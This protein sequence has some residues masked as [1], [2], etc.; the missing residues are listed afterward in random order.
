[1]ATR[2]IKDKII[3]KLNDFFEIDIYE[4]IEKRKKKSLGFSQNCNNFNLSYIGGRKDILK[5]VPKTAKKVLDVGCSTGAVGETIRQKIGDVEISGI[6][7]SERMAQ[8]ARG[9][10]DKVVIEDIEKLNPLEQFDSNYFDCIIFADILEHLKNPWVVLKNMI[11]I[12]DE[13]GLVILSIPNIRHYS[14]IIQLVFK[15]YW[16][17][18]ERGIHDK[19]H[20]RF[21][22]LKNIKELLE[23]AGLEP[24]NIRRKYRI[25]ERPHK[26]NLFAKFF[27]LPILRVFLTFQYVIC[28]KKKKTLHKDT[29]LR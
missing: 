23:Y 28:A 3:D 22:T 19:T 20:L 21:F 24:V 6:E 29:N 7:I 14:T 9:K 16:P 1:M 25:I 27:A 13:E 12:L 2:K 8:I 15:G 5:L 10:L 4:Y 18:R 11:Q 26:I 17:Y